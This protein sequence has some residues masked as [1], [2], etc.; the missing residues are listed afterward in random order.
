[1]TKEE[2]KK[3]CKQHNIEIEAILNDI[4]TINTKKSKN[5][6]IVSILKN[7]E[8]IAKGVCTCDK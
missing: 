5:K 1:M 7:A 8:S 6:V 3:I 2:L 4:D